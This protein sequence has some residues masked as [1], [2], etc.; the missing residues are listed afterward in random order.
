MIGWQGKF[1]RKGTANER[2]MSPGDERQTLRVLRGK[3]H[4]P[5]AFCEHRTGEDEVGNPNT[6]LFLIVL[7]LSDCAENFKLPCLDGSM[8]LSISLW[9]SA[10]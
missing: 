5:N 8:S 6:G 7:D 4:A 2:A 1:I 3:R 9:A 10:S